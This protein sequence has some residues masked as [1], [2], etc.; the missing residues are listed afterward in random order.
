MLFESFEIQ[1]KNAEA[2]EK[3]A[4]GGNIGGV[5]LQGV[6]RRAEASQAKQATPSINYEGYD[7]H[8]TEIK[9]KYEK[10]KKKDMQTPQRMEEKTSQNTLDDILFVK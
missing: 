9:L 1:K 6:I 7:K 4:H 2:L 5:Q 10:P 3:I 8:E